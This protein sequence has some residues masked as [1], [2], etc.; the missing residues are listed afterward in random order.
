M[1]PWILL[2]ASAAGLVFLFLRRLRM[3][4]KDLVFQ[5]TLEKEEDELEEAEME[6]KRADPEPAELLG[7]I[8]KT[9]LKADTH[10]SRNEHEEAEPL[11]L[12]V[13]EADP[14]HLEAHHKLGL[15]FMKRGDF[16]QAEFYFSKLV[17]LKQDPVYFSN[18]GAALYQ[19]QRLVEA[20]EAY[21]NAIAL[22]DKRG[23][24]LQSLGQVYYELGEDDK[25]LHYF[26]CAAR[27]K[28]KDVNLKLILADYYERL[29]RLADAVPVLKEILE[30]EPYNDEAKKKL[31][32][33]G[34]AGAAL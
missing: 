12:A 7:T 22:D 26:E 15:M 16:P 21:E 6:E 31:K 19:Q 29:G 2:I 14:G 33:I 25:A 5:E 24:R 18:L 3:T 13:I 1:L 23:E 32:A 8:R 9:F 20:A 10:L 11:L 17:N 30:A 27:R 28:P 34:K 4:R